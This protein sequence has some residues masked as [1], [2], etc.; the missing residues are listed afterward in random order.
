MLEPTWTEASGGYITDGAFALLLENDTRMRHAV[1]AT[2][3]GDLLACP[4]F[5]D[6]VYDAIRAFRTI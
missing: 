1:A 4:R 2:G 6:R 5:N 3:W